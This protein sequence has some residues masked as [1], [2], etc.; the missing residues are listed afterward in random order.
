[1]Q[2]TLDRHLRSWGWAG[3]AA[4][5]ALALLILGAWAVVAGV[6][7]RDRYML[8]HVS[9][10]WIGLAYWAG[11]GLFYPPPMWEGLYGGTRWGPIP[12][13]LQG[14][15]TTW[16]GEPMFAGK[17]LVMGEMAAVLGLMMAV[18]RRIGCGWTPAL[19]LAAGVVVTATGWMAGLTIRHD[20]L[21]VAMQLV[22]LWL[23]LDVGRDPVRGRGGW[24]LPLVAGLLCGAAVLAKASSVW[25]GL[26]LAVWLAVHH[27]RVLPWLVL[28]GVL[29]MWATS[30][31]AYWASDGRWLVNM[32]LYLLAGESAGGG[33]A[34]I[35]GAV[36]TVFYNLAHSQVVA[37]ALIPA[38]G[39]TAAMGIAHRRL[40]PIIACLG[41]CCL[42]TAY[43][44]T[45]PG[46]IHNHLL[47]LVVLLALAAG[48]LA[49]R[50]RPLSNT[51]GRDAIAIDAAI[52]GIGWRRP[53]A[54]LYTFLV[55]MFAWV[56]G[57]AAQTGGLFGEARVAAAMAMGR[58]AGERSWAVDSW[59]DILHDTT[60]PVWAYDASLPIA[61]GET[62]VV[63]DTFMLRRTLDRDAT[64]HRDF[65]GR[66]ERQAFEA[67]VLPP[68]LES[69]TDE[70]TCAMA[71]ALREHY[72]PAGEL[73]GDVVWRR[74]RRSQGAVARGR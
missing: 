66:L 39:A 53:N 14:L 25:G 61:M 67:V 60:G 13:A 11:Q 47:P 74:E 6:H 10:A 35:G 62:P 23:V 7:L 46:I 44:F 16:T 50:V 57:S 19:L 42:T 51:A 72:R 20:A 15:L 52:E 70:L 71:Q 30:A 21:P 27:R 68:G 69:H 4:G 18:L 55:L 54:G 31:A 73:W 32:R 34:Q 65:V 1:M 22:A 38:A 56:A 26:G 9:G 45:S 37:W 17:L 63:L 49:A 29:G 28:G 48:E 58:S 36:R 12:I 8:D 59:R 33:V 41:A 43:V 64:A 2:R 40:S 24:S 5:I 3:R